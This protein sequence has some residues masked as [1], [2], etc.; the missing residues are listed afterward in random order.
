MWDAILAIMGQPAFWTC[1]STVGIGILGWLSKKKVDT[2]RWDRITSILFQ[3][4][5]RQQREKQALAALQDI[6]E[7]DPSI[8]NLRPEEVELLRPL[9]HSYTR[10]TSGDLA[11]MAKQVREEE[12]RK[13]RP[14]P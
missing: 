11:E 14:K 3:L 4:V 5:Q 13:L 8:K 12:A 10:A 9:V 7:N 2:H 1:L 6:V